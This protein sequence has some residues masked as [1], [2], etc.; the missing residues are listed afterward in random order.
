M[1]EKEGMYITCAHCEKNGDGEIQEAA[2]VVKKERKK[3]KTFNIQRM[4]F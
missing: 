2:H 1:G 3:A 4:A